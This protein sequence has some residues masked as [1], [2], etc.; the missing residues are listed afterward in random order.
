MHNRGLPAAF[1]TRADDPGFVR[2]RPGG[3]G[4]V[5]AV[6]GLHETGDR[7]R[8]LVADGLGQDAADL[9]LFGMGQMRV[10]R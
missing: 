3:R 7:C 5:Q 10:D 4:I 6:T 8:T 2:P 1:S 9:I